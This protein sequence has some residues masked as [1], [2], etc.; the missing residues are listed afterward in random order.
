MI[1]VTVEA[2]QRVEAERVAALKAAD[3][4]PDDGPGHGPEEYRRPLITE[5][6]EADSP[7][8]S[9]A[10]DGMPA[11]HAR[12]VNL[13]GSQAHGVLIPAHVQ[14]SMGPAGGSQ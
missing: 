14:A 9:P 5:G 3:V 2:R 8:N 11:P 7:Q 4:Y 12:H 1:P 10:S 13:T 6:H